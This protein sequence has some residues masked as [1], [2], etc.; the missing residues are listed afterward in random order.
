[1]LQVALAQV[2]VH[3]R[4][5]IAVGLA[6]ML[7]VAFLA[8][9]LMV[10]AT[11][12]AS[13]R[14]SVGASYATADLVVTADDG[15]GV[16]ADAVESLGSLPG[17][18][19]VYGLE[20]SFTQLTTGSETSYAVLTSV[21][22]PE[23]EGAVIT[24]GS[25]PRAPGEVVL[26]ETSAERLGVVPGDTVAID[27]AAASAAGPDATSLGNALTVTGLMA[28]SADPGL[29]GAVQVLASPTIIRALSGGETY[30]RNVQL[31]LAPGADA[32]ATRDA[33]TTAVAA[34]TPSVDG[35]G[36][37][38]VRTAGEQTTA[39]V[40]MLS[41]GSD[42]LTGILL[43]FAAVAVIVAGL[44]ISN[45]FSVLVAQRTRELALLRCI[46]AERRQVRA[47]VLVEAAL[48]GLVSSV[49]GVLLAVGVMAALVGLA[50]QT[51]FGSFAT[52]AVPASAVLIALSVGILMTLLA[53]LVPARAATRVAPLAALRPTEPPAAGTRSGR[54]RLGAGLAALA[55]GVVLLA[56]GAATSAILPAVAGGAVSFLGIILLAPF[57]VPASVAAIGRIA[58]P[59]GVPGNLAS[60]NAIRNPGRTTASSAAL[61]VGVTLVTMMMVGA[62]TARTTFDRELDE[63]YA[64]DLQ[65]SG[66]GTLSAGDT[67]AASPVDEP[68]LLAIDGVESAVE[69]TPVM[70]TSPEDGAW[71][72]YAADP[73][74]LAQVL[75][76]SGVE[77]TDGMVLAPQTWEQD[78][79]TLEGGNGP[80]DLP[81]VATDAGFFQ[82]LITTATA[83][84]LG[85]TPP[86]ALASYLGDTDDTGPGITGESLSAYLGATVWLK[87]DDG[88][89]GN[90]VAE[91]QS[92]IVAATGI[93]EYN[94]TGAAIERLAYNQIIDVM[95]LIVTALLAVAVLIALIGVANTLSLSVLERRRENSLLRALGL[96]RGQLRGMLAVE[97]VLIA[98]VAALLGSGLGVLYG[99]LGAQSALGGIASVTPSIP[100]GQIGAVL[101][102]AVAAGL[103]ASVLP[104]RRAA[105]L[106]PVAGLAA[107]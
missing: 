60:V 59:L 88:L 52:L 44:V 50:R 58:R 106:S 96:T 4:R 76:L 94:V 21:A 57:F 15:S 102:I 47:S 31:S 90:G 40:A 66:P 17:V 30:V 87:L 9:T 27:D 55:V 2:R 92:Q 53:A 14:Q 35:A 7:G 72:V 86:D 24:S 23:L 69:I 32:G 39:D 3:A 79:V 26:D 63:N 18:D 62:Q 19:A 84:R 107:D 41:N 99:W 82:P 6:V 73:V 81:V 46:G 103:L 101:A 49:L 100:L 95:L 74:Q 83:E 78:Q 28:P 93:S 56:F 36:A 22:P 29:S 42:L 13:L 45:T 8:A 33:A 105:R 85:G 89:D 37:L 98:G 16:P 97:A 1:M 80:A 71:L 61:M 20:R 65:V 34:A 43:A 54:M 70:L 64:V 91:V 25:A 68:T 75:R 104:A 5:F 48:V 12:N 67:P 38:T 51:E 77:L 10:G 11:T